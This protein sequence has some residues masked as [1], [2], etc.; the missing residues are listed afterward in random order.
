M[1][2]KTSEVARIPGSAKRG[3]A[4]MEHQRETGE[5]GALPSARW[6]RDGHSYIQTGETAGSRV[7]MKHQSIRG[8]RESPQKFFPL[9][10][11]KH[12]QRTKNRGAVG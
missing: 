3:L 10:W 5:Q 1:R 4:V 9:P 2:L 6:G 12:S 7:K 8:E 11:E